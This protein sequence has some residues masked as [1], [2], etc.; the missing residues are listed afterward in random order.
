MTKR[1][2]ATFAIIASLA[3]PGLALAHAGHAHKVMGTISSIDGNHVMVKTQDGKTVMVMLDAKTKITQGKITLAA[4]ALKVGD[5]LVAEGA[6]DKGM[7][8]AATV[9]VG[10]ATPTTARK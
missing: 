6:E 10:Q 7:V 5:R 9:R 1:L 8:T 3:L 2:I 4:S